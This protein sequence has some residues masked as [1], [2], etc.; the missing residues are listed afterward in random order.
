MSA[1]LQRWHGI[2]GSLPV[3]AILYYVGLLAVSYRRLPA[4]LPIHFGFDGG[5]NGWM[6]RGLWLILSPLILLSLMMLVFMT[7]PLGSGVAVNFT[8]FMF[9]WASG[10]VIGSFVQIV[11]AARADGEFRFLPLIGWM[12]LLPICETVLAIASKP[13]WTR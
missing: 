9:W 6:N 8:T 4:E 13:W 5:A 7:R 11:Q 2:A 3:L 12:I 1:D 10:L